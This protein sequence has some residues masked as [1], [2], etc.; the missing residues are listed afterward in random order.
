LE[1]RRYGGKVGW[2]TNDDQLLLSAHSERSTLIYEQEPEARGGKGPKLTAAD[3]NAIAEDVTV[4]GGNA[5]S[6]G[7]QK[8]VWKVIESGRRSTGEFDSDTAPTG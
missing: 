5:R 6:G 3:W 4:K 1:P 8:S 7:A 2:T